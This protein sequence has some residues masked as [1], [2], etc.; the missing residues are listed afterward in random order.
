MR[1]YANFSLVAG[2]SGVSDV[3]SPGDIVHGMQ[4]LDPSTQLS[5][6]VEN[7]KWFR[8][9]SDGLKVAGDVTDYLDTLGRTNPMQQ[10]TNQ[11]G[12]LS[13]KL[14]NRL[15]ETVSPYHAGKRLGNMLEAENTNMMR[16]GFPDITGG[17]KKGLNAVGDVAVKL[18]APKVADTVG[19]KLSNSGSMPNI[20]QTLQ[21]G[22]GLDVLQ[23]RAI[24]QVLE[25]GEGLNILQSRAIPQTLQGGEGLSVNMPNVSSAETIKQ[26]TPDPR[27][28]ASEA[29]AG[30]LG[31][32]GLLSSR[33]RNKSNKAVQPATNAV[34]DMPAT[35]SKINPYLMG[36][37]VL[38][39]SAG[40]GAGG[41]V[42]AS[43]LRQED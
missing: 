29:G 28:V 39:G 17:L 25:G 5:N 20:P 23:S 42:A 7:A 43:K 32:G 18:A 27:A 33:L 31:L 3:I 2:L 12:E 10:F 8:D 34:M 14:N 37:G 30:V 35:S 13:D 24:P 22:E 41:T 1:R 6:A 9:N 4:N 26:L 15:L 11:V 36:G 21:G 19:K 16:H 38:A 40:L